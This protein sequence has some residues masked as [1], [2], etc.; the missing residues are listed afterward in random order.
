MHRDSFNLAGKCLRDAC[1]TLNAI[2]H[3]KNKLKNS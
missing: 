1:R 3:R 2:N